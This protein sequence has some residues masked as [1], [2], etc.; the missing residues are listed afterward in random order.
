MFIPKPEPGEYAPYAIEYINLL[1]DDGQVFRHLATNDKRM[2]DQVRS[3]PA[4][5]LITP[6]AAGEWTVQDILVHVIDTERVFA[7]RALRIARNDTTELPGFPHEEYVP[8]AQANQR[9]LDDILAEYSTVRHATLSLLQSFDTYALSNAARCNQQL[10]S[11][12]ALVYDIAGHE[13]H[14]LHSIQ[15]NYG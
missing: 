4:E 7:Y 10:T 8:A 15:Q 11:L 1:P 3:L 6:H 13:L 5:K 12:R 14:H 9:S 2:R